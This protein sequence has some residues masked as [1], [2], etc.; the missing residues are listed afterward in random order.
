MKSNLFIYLANNIV[1]FFIYIDIDRLIS[2][3][4][5]RILNNNNNNNNNEG[6]GVV[7]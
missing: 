2:Y 6:E 7:V 1:L 4:V 3:R 5:Y